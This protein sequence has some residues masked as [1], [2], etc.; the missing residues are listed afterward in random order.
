MDTEPS[1]VRAAR[2]IRVVFGRLRRRLRELAR[3][4]DLTPSQI[5]VLTRL[6]KSGPAG[7]SGLAAAERVRPQS[8]AATLAVLEQHALISRRP[9][10]SDGRR[11]V[12]SL[13]AEGVARVQGDRLARQEWLA[14][15]LDQGFTEEERETIVRAMGLLDR[16]NDR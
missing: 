12:V 11:Q 14:R 7:A 4:E 6:D 1:A 5:S 13:T 16:L 2:E 9:D 3:A 15:E 8:M 10:P